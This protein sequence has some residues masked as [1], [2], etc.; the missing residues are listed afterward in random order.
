MIAT[1]PIMA[2]YLYF[3]S[4]GFQFKIRFEIKKGH[5]HDIF[6]VGRLTKA[7]FGR[8][9]SSK[10][11]RYG[12]TELR[13]YREGLIKTK[14]QNSQRICLRLASGMKGPNSSLP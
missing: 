8:R 14:I 6:L 11:P 5:N 3:R 1:R 2:I 9:K 10:L 12:V 7:S 4:I 13:S